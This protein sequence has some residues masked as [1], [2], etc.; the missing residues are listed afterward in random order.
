MS[1]KFGWI[2]SLLLMSG[3]LYTIFYFNHLINEIIQLYDETNFALVR[4]LSG[5]VLAFSGSLFLPMSF[6]GIIAVIG[7]ITIWKRYIGLAAISLILATLL[8]NWV[9]SILAITGAILGFIMWREQP[10]KDEVQT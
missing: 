2:P 6:G 7:L 3:G 4:A 8:L 9:G 10:L 5:V 1:K